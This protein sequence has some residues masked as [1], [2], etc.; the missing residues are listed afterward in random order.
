MPG[1]SG[2]WGYGGCAY[3]GCVVADVWGVQMTVDEFSKELWELLDPYHCF[4]V[5][6]AHQ[7]AVEQYRKLVREN[8]ELRAKLNEVETEL[9]VMRGCYDVRG[10]CLAEMTRHRDEWRRHCKRISGAPELWPPDRLEWEG[11]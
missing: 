3:V 9:S 1:S 2:V 6:F 8:E 5:R 10:N 11:E 4:K 7:R